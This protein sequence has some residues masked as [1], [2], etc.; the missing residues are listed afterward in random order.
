M[1]SGE[2]RVFRQPGVYIFINTFNGKAYCGSSIN[3][4][5]RVCTEHLSLNLF[6]KERSSNIYLQRALVKYPP[7]VFVLVIA[8]LVPMESIDTAT[9]KERL[10]AR[11][12]FYLNLI[13]I[14]FQYNFARVA[15]SNLGFKHTLTT[16]AIL[17]QQRKGVLKTEE[18]KKNM[19]K[20]NR[21]SVAVLITNEKEGITFDASSFTQASKNFFSLFEIKVS[22]KTLSSYLNSGKLLFNVWKIEK[23]PLL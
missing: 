20:S 19:A 8:E 17:S 13:P 11:E 16:K 10:L 1:H 14:E 3:M 7:N 23:L 22:R 21:K 9:F 6:I 4:E 12:Q 18:A 5:K 2:M 15:G